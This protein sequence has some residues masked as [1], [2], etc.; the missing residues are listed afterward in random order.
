MAAARAQDL[1]HWPYGS[2]VMA[3][4]IRAHDWAGTPLGPI[5]HWP[6]S[7]KTV[8][9][10]MLASPSMMSLVWGA[11]A[12]HLYND[13]FTELLREHHMQALGTS[14]LETF[15]E[16]RNVFAADLAAGMAG[17]SAR[18]L[19]QRYPVLRG[20][21]VKD[22][23][24]DVD[25]APVRDEAG[26]VAGVLWTLREV[27]AQVLAERVLRASETRHRLLIK[28]WTQAVWET[29]ADGVVVADSPSWRAY[30][31]QTLDE[32]LGYGWL[33]AVHPEDRAFAERQWRD[34]IAAVSVVNAEFRLRA[35]DGGWRWTN[36]RAAPVLD[37]DGGVEEWVGMNID[38][39]ARRRAEEAL[40]AS[41]EKFRRLFDAIDEGLAVV[42]MIYDDR[43]EIVDII[44][45]Q[46]NSAYE[47]QGGVH[48]VIGRSI[49]D[50][51]P[52]VE[53]HWLRPYKEVART[54]VAQRVENYQG[55]VDRWFDVYFSR[56]DDA[57]RF[58]AIVF[59]DIT[60]RKR[61]ERSTRESE[62]RQAFLL[63][64]GDALRAEPNADAI[65]RRAVELLSSHMEL[66]RCY[67]TYYRP[68]DDV[69]EFPYQVGN[70]TV[71]PLPATV[72]LS[73]FP[74]AYEQVLDGTFVV[75]DDFERRGPSGAE[76][77][78][79]AALG[80]RA[81]VA[82]TVRKGEN[83]PL[84]SLAAV[85]SRP[86]N[87]TAGEVA[88][89]EEVA[90]RT[91]SAI[92]RAR[93]EAALRESDARLAQLADAAPVLI[94]ETDENGATFVNSHYL[95]YFG[96]SFEEIAGLG[97]ARFVHP[98]D[99]DGYVAAYSQAFAER[100][101]YDY[102]CRFLRADGRNRWH[103]TS[104]GP[105]GN[106]RFIGSSTDI[107]DLVVAERVLR[108]REERLRGVLDGMAEGFGVIAP[109]FTILEYNRE[110]LRM[111][112]RSRD[113]IVGRSHWDA[114]PGTEHSEVG[115]LLK[116]A[117]A[118]RRPATLVHR[119]A[120]VTGGTAWLELR[121]HPTTDGALAVFWRDVTE[122]KV[123]E[124]ALRESEERYRR[125]FTSMDEAYAV[126]DV[127]KDEAGR[128]TNFRFVEVNPAFVEHTSMPWPVGKTATELLGTPNPRW[129]RL[130][131]EALDANR[132]IR[133][134]EE[135]P[136][137]GRTFDLNIFTLDRERDRVAV[138]FTNITD[139]KKAEA[140][141][142]ASEELRRIALE[143]GGMGAWT[144]NTR[145]RTIWADEAVQHLWGVS[146][147]QQ[148][149][150][151]STYAERMFPEGV[152]WLEAEMSREP[153]PG[154]Q[155]DAQLQVAKGATSSRWVQLLGRAEREKPW[156]INGVSFDMTER[157][158]WE[159]RQRVLVAELQHR[160][161]NL[162]GVVRS[163][164]D[165]TAR[166]SADLSDFRDRFRVRL[167][168]L[169]RVQGLLSRL[170]EHDR[171]TF[172]ELIETELAAMGG[173]AD[174]VRLDGP[175]GVRLRSSMVQTLAM[176]LHELATNAVKY[177]ALGQPG[178]RLAV[179]WRLT[180]D[181]GAD[182]PRLLMDWRECGVEMPPAGSKP[183]GGGQGR[184]LIEK[185]LPYQL[186]AETS[187]ELGP[188]GV[189]CTIS[190]PISTTPAQ[191]AAHA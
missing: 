129:T 83:R 7:L 155:V 74:D 52:G 24:F 174:R 10:L 63:K 65:A 22:A 17:K 177:G 95:A 91:W 128:W 145:D 43:G 73:D 40:R 90:E 29:D 173:G 152:A 134:E 124:D 36:V 112:G 119:Y 153:A 159:E 180:P 186:S 126:V 47:R 114:F 131:G 140:A 178:G 172:D 167:E 189:H 48:D 165:K 28:S 156:I 34:A 79:S 75:E 142:R 25:Y 136:T 143:S 163:M 30:T 76:R 146:T 11:D 125:L 77:A 66:D 169:A 150:P 110:A 171:V 166:A 35:P 9:D 122:R 99:V 115:R 18:L 154:E 106:G 39:D 164:A 5:A 20:G 94:W 113:E 175:R 107:H 96:I 27:S 190:I 81:M 144:W 188:D 116:T 185:A 98:D 80:M 137:L 37:P 6:Q 50:V 38:V 14:A 179:T 184:E 149:H 67:I 127:L 89:V 138:L 19:A 191:G 103:R 121:V 181:G 88:L 87:W 2:G 123:A 26:Q 170:N 160:T 69:A 148:P 84:A 12:T 53:E 49:F 168:A 78:N 54:G 15:A 33:H 61:A 162:I 51:I 16:A 120:S 102:E 42:E 70:A 133:V 46:T 117:M 57:G 62:A 44:Y 13:H 86:R 108:E 59:N 151:I 85:C 97:W 56:V 64:L 104:G 182:R 23:W 139:R 71:P 21:R 45:R 157:K 118:D 3:A 93:A 158:H 100:R 8:V 135:E 105:A 72:R 109:D 187:Y 130:Y 132:S 101:P 55:D 111:D 58:V 176:G 31:G 1:P 147:S 82:S 183:G 41:E 32:W 4:R 92:E 161:R 60:E 68:D 141:L